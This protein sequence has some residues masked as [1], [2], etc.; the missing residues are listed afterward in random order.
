[1]LDSR[2]SKREQGKERGLRYRKNGKRNEKEGE[3]SWK[4]YS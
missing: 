1:M 3:E 4:M 2:D